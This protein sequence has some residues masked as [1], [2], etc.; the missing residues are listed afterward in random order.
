[1][2]PRPP[3]GGRVARLADAPMEVLPHAVV[4]WSEGLPRSDAY[5]DVY[6]AR[7]GGP[8]QARDVFLGGCGLPAG[9]RGRERFT[10]LETGFGGGTNFLA[11]REAWQDDQ[12][13]GR[14]PGRLT[15]I[16]CE[17]HPWS[18]D[19]LLRLHGQGPWAAMVRELCAAWPL[20][21][22]GFHARDF[23][24]GRVRL[25]LLLGDAQGQ[26]AQLQARVDAFYLDGF[27]PDRNPEM[28]SPALLGR[29][30][31]LAGP[32]AV[33]ASYTVA[34]PVRAGLALAGF[35]VERRAGYGRKRHALVA[36]FVGRGDSRDGATQ[37]RPT[38]KPTHPRSVA[39][40]GAGVA[41]LS[42]A[43]A[44]AR[45]GLR[46]TVH[47]PADH[48]LGGASGNVRAVVR[49]WWTRTDTAATRLTR[50]AYGF[51]LPYY[52]RQP[53]AEWQGTG[54]LQLPHE[55]RDAGRSS[56]AT[57][58]GSSGIASGPGFPEPLDRE[59]ASRWAGL[60]LPEDAWLDRDAGY[61][62]P[63]GWAAALADR[64][65]IETRLGEDAITDPVRLAKAHDA[66]I[67]ACGLASN[68]YLRLPIPL[69]RVRG[70]LTLLPPG[71]LPGLKAIVARAGHVVPLPGGAA[72][73]GATYDRYDS[74]EPDI[75]GHEANLAR[76]AGLMVTL[77]R[78]EPSRLQGR[79]A[80]RAVLP[81][82]L[83]ALGPVEG[84]A[85]GTAGSP[86]H[87]LATGYA[88]RGW[89]WAPL[90]AELLA[91][92][93]LDEPWPLEADLAEAL[94]PGRFLAG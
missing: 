58:S 27:A 21:V 36:R 67:I 79:A 50:A 45:R 26:L 81:G 9:W 41:G 93:M 34:A 76:L 78:L 89:V 28:W 52:A 49:P 16:A 19:D 64:P 25:L 88:S 66:V 75:A 56:L 73:V 48:L 14:M 84:A 61:L 7:D 57:S 69:H 60:E 29:L 37:P 51:A 5:G 55:A 92:Q 12:R 47:D 30:G 2:T 24:G 40:L 46:V 13:A 83:P 68:T 94:A 70:Q 42:I 85:D 22:A 65:G 20:A 18:S 62:S 15:Y 43:A 35:E 33:A 6:H 74:L 8:G 10:I 87:W 38:D 80:F 3:Q 4:D 77:P 39:I 86:A 32:G 82:R 31:R 63:V 23:E 1:M 72:M 54:A 91:A 53:G 71:S 11:T 90:L 17:R 59:A 44:L